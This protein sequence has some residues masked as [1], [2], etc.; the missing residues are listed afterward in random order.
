MSITIHDEITG[1]DILQVPIIIQMYTCTRRVRADTYI[2]TLCVI[3]MCSR[4]RGLQIGTATL[5]LFRSEVASWVAKRTTARASTKRFG[6]YT[7]LIWTSILIRFSY[8]VRYNMRNQS[9]N[10]FRKLRG[11]YTN[12]AFVGRV[13]GNNFIERLRP[14][15]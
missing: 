10:N 8:I 2:Y 5:Y 3:R 1:A 15:K 14:E 6:F 4:F 11:G 12:K 7:F 9:L 13:S